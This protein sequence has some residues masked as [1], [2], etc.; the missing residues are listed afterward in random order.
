MTAG[1][2]PVR[3]V[4]PAFSRRRDAPSIRKVSSHSTQNPFGIVFGLEAQGPRRTHGTALP[5][6]EGGKR[7]GND[8]C[9]AI[10]K[11]LDKERAAE[12]LNSGDSDRKNQHAADRAPD[13]DPAGFDRVRAEKRADERRQEIIK[14]DIRLADSEL[15]TKHAAGKTRNHACDDKHADDIGPHRNAVERGRLLVGANRIDMPA[16]R[17]ALADNPEHDRQNEDIDRWNRDSKDRGRID[18]EKAR[19]KRPYNLASVRMPKRERIED[20]AD[21]QRGDERINLRHFDQQAVDEADQPA[22]G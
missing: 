2:G 5:L 14:P 19:R 11:R 1:S 12:L 6:S 13:V 15:C 21:A 18:R 9:R 10:E 4:T 17:E 22:A 3:L 20:R 8:E 7:D 16:N